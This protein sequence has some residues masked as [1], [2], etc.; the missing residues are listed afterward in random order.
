MLHFIHSLIKALA[1]HRSLVCRR[2][3]W[4]EG[5]T[6]GS[7]FFD[8]RGWLESHV[9]FIHR[10]C[11]AQRGSCLV[12][13]AGMF[14]NLSQRLEGVW[15]TV[16]KDGKLT[17]DNIKTPMREIRRALL[18]ADVRMSPSSPITCMH[19]CTACSVALKLPLVC[20]HA[21]CSFMRQVNTHCTTLCGVA[22]SLKAVTLSS[23]SVSGTAARRASAAN[24]KHVG[25]RTQVSLPVVRQF[26]SNVEAKALGTKV[27]KGVRPDQQLV[28]VVNDQLVELMGGQQEDL[29]DPK[30]GPQVLLCFDHLNLARV[31]HLG[32]IKQVRFALEESLIPVFPEDLTRIAFD[33]ICHFKREAAQIILPDAGM[34]P[35]LG[36][37]F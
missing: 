4:F 35:H 16:R 21:S 22:G 9:S 34:Q 19:A 7:P 30:D 17:A 10:G 28:K 33:Q 32:Y 8:P 26:V 20:V 25:I 23:M 27:I 24:W 29:N 18:E 31:Q 37:M 2:S 1:T 6:S 14:D 11:V 15:D 3:W 12:V 36:H 5:S 13:R